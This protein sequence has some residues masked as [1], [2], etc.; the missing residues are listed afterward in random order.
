VISF[1]QMFDEGIPGGQAKL[2][3]DQVVPTCVVPVDTQPETQMRVRRVPFP[4][5]HLLGS[6]SSPPTVTGEAFARS[7]V[8]RREPAERDGGLVLG[9]PGQEFA[10]RQ[11]S[12]ILAAII[13][14]RIVL[15]P[16]TGWICKDGL[17]KWG[18][19]RTPR[20]A[21][22]DWMEVISRPLMNAGMRRG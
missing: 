3:N 18:I 2:F 8:E 12:A 21:Y 13:K 5:P 16:G 15:R 7:Q 10:A 11:R 22:L 20:E 4:S 1:Q 17:S 9:Q 14:P 6:V 19:G